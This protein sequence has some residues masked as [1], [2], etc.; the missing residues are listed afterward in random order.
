MGN[1]IILFSSLIV[2]FSLTYCPYYFLIKNE[3][4]T[5]FYPHIKLYINDIPSKSRNIKTSKLNKKRIKLRLKPDN[6]KYD[7]YDLYDSKKSNKS[8]NDTPVTFKYEKEIPKN[9]FN[10]EDFLEF[11]FINEY[12]IN[13]EKEDNIPDQQSLVALTD[14]INKAFLYNPKIK[15]QKSLFKSSKENITQVRSNFLPSIDVNASKGFTKE[16]SK[17]STISSNGNRS[18]QDFSISLEQDLYRG[19]KLSAEMNKAKNEYLIEKENLKLVKQEI[20]I[21]S[22]KVFLEVLQQKKLVEL[23]TLK[24]DRFSQDLESIELLFKIGKASQSDL[25][26]AKS[27][28]VKATTEKMASTNELEVLKIK[29][30]SVVGD[31]IIESQLVEPEFKKFNLPVDY[32]L[33]ET[34]A[35]KNNSKYKKLLIEEKISKNEIKSHFA[36]ALPS[37]SLDA[38]YRTADDFTSKGSSSD[39]AEITAELT[40]PLFRGGKNLSKIKQAKLIAKK[41]TGVKKKV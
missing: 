8:I 7:H 28:L 14:T 10:Q 39:T 25:L 41:V 21:E 16:D 22:A 17:S 31:F 32:I 11:N 35:L 1:F 5:Q 29:Y 38:E 24:E 6:F 3:K 19:G 20:I 23:N 13:N 37:V 2:S 27:Q 12:K 33:A 26:F 30:K 34:L 36:D 9:D 4:K 18:P 15:A 40:I